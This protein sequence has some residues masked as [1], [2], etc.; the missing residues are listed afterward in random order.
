MTKYWGDFGDP[1]KKI[2]I[3]KGVRE[4]TTVFGLKQAKDFVD[5]LD[6]HYGH[7]ISVRC[8]NALIL[9]ALSVKSSLTTGLN[10]EKV[11]VLDKDLG[12]TPSAGP[13]AG[14]PHCDMD[15]IMEIARR[16]RDDD[17]EIWVLTRAKAAGRRAKA[18]VEVHPRAF[19]SVAAACVAVRELG[20]DWTI[21]S[22]KA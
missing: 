18:S 20:S 2:A 3:I 10:V 19:L 7:G 14:K 16:N 15:P 11:R 17:I 8:K 22:I 6:G 9:R 21:S 5:Y 1:H 13:A 4:T 12:K